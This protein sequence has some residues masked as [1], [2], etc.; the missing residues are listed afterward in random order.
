MASSFTYPIMVLYYWVYSIHVIKIANG[1][2][3]KAVGWICTNIDRLVQ[4][5][6]GKKTSAIKAISKTIAPISTD[7]LKQVYNQKGKFG[8][9]PSEY[10][11]S[12]WIPTNWFYANL[13]GQQTG[14]RHSCFAKPHG[15]N[16]AH[17]HTLLCNTRLD[18]QVERHHPS[19][20]TWGNQPS[21]KS[22]QWTNKSVQI[23]STI[24]KHLF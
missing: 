9:Y 16:E 7:A 8:S 23:P 19:A 11:Y 3:K 6:G 22:R 13:Q 1:S 24:I 17:W 5:H 15:T 12:P 14:H 18:S 21:D 20:Y 10:H 2:D 4:T